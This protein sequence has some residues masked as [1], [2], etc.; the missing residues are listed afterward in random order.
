[1]RVRDEEEV[2]VYRVLVDARLGLPGSWREAWCGAHPVA[3]L[4]PG[5]RTYR[6][7]P[8]TRPIRDDMRGSMCTVCTPLLFWFLGF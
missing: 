8:S 5:A 6:L 7:Q 2:A 1:M 4:T 3:A